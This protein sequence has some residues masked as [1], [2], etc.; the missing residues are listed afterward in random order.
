MF[1]D[2][3]RELRR[4][5]EAERVIGGINY[6]FCSERFMGVWVTANGKNAILRNDELKAFINN[7]T[8]AAI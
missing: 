6:S 2:I 8:E 4:T 1:G 7:V 3:M 5:G